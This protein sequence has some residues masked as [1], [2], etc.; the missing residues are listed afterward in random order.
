MSDIS[1]FEL[2]PYLCL[3]LSV[4][5]SLRGKNPVVPMALLVPAVILGFLNQMFAPLGLLVLIL[6][7]VSFFVWV[8]HF[9][10]ELMR[11]L[12]LVVFLVC[13]VILAIHELPGLNN[14]KLFDQVVFSDNSAPFNMY[15][16]FDKAYLGIVMFNLLPPLDKVVEFKKSLWL[17]FRYL[18]VTALFLGPAAYFSGYVLWEPKA[19]PYLALWAL[20]NFF[21]VCFFEETI[22]RRFIQ[23]QLVH[24]FRNTQYGDL[25]A[26]FLGAVI[27]GLAHIAGGMAYVALATLAGIFYGL[28]FYHSCNVRTS[29]LLH[30]SVNLIHSL[31]FTYPFYAS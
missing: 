30:F 25:V 13:A 19:N 26:I 24:Y 31:L 8:N 9:F 18:L 5:F 27:F 29:M 14:F 23:N 28:C 11:K 12:G 6:T 2:S 4:L 7:P 16:N 22:F 17:V 15:L 20:N 3:F 10:A 1:F 21:F